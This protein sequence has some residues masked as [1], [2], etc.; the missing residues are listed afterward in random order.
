MANI[1]PGD[2]PVTHFFRAASTACSQPPHGGH[3][4]GP[5]ALSDRQSRPRPA[6]FIDTDS[7]P[8][9]DTPPGTASDR[10]VPRRPT[11]ATGTTLSRLAVVRRELRTAKP[12]VKPEGRNAND[13][14]TQTGPQIVAIASASTIVRS[15]SRIRPSVAIEN[16]RDKSGTQMP[17]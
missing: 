11:L 15:R 7:L 1:N 16:V 10:D 17:R 4:F 5:Q 13:G 9:T 3:S 2:R 8:P 14:I 6:G 12:W